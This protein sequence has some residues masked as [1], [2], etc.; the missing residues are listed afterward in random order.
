MQQLPV[1]YYA[2]MVGLT[3]TRTDSFQYPPVFFLFVCW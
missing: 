2:E 3:D 1:E